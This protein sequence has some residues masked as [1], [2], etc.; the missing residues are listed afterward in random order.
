MKPQKS[1]YKFNNFHW[2]ELSNESFAIQ[3]SL[4]QQELASKKN[5]AGLLLGLS[6]DKPTSD[7]KWRRLA[8][9]D[10]P[11]DPTRP[12]YN[13]PFCNRREQFYKGWVLLFDD[14]TRRLIG[15]DC[16]ATHLGAEKWQ[17]SAADFNFA[18][19]VRLVAEIHEKIDLLIDVKKEIG[20]V[21]NSPMANDIRRVKIEFSRKIPGLHVK[22]QK[23]LG[24]AGQ[25]HDLKVTRRQKHSG[26]S[27]QSQYYESVVARV[28]GAIG[29]NSVTHS[30]CNTLIPI[31][32]RLQR[33]ID[34]AK[35]FSANIG[36]KRS[37]EN[38]I[39][40][41]RKELSSIVRQCQNIF[42]AGRDISNFFS[43][44][45]LAGLIRWADDPD[46]D[47][48]EKGAVTVDGDFLVYRASR[49]DTVRLGLQHRWEM[50]QMPSFNQLIAWLGVRG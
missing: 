40:E 26:H 9:T 4:I 2:D 38:K 23:A 7:L 5:D 11:L 43:Q 48:N 18:I 44:S 45:N 12:M 13:C 1:Q 46:S 22:L 3:R 50:P 49:E 24:S 32:D 27:S 35:G 19:V 16:A 21:R 15:D 36:D 33:M 6:N 14:M 42:E 39:N 17:K 29:I 20:A 37:I 10:R 28:S 25:I 31:E 47:F 30:P 41:I 8:R 34:R